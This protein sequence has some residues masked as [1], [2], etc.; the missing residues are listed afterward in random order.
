MLTSIDRIFK[1][2]DEICKLIIKKDDYSLMWMFTSIILIAGAIYGFIMGIYTSFLQALISAVKVPLLFFVTLVICIPTLHFMGLFIGS[3]LRIVQT[4]TILL[5]AIAINCILLAA[6]AP[7]S[8]FFLISHS[9]YQF[10]ITLH[11][12]IFAIC[13]LAGLNYIYR[14]FNSIK[15]LLSDPENQEKENT[16]M[17]I[18]FV[19]MI[20]F[21]F[22]GCQMSYLLSPYLGN[23]NQFMFFGGSDYNFYTYLFQKLYH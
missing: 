3:K 7:I 9:T 11:V 4:T 17:L 8:L 14:N 1:D 18:L 6:F 23:V 21:M 15:T 22:V 13:G 19:W 5:W 2:T 10:M 12:I 20:L 16:S